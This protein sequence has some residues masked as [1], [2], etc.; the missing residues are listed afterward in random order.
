MEKKERKKKWFWGNSIQELTMGA[1]REEK[2]I[3][4]KNRLVPL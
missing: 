1:E 4:E 3:Y 2:K